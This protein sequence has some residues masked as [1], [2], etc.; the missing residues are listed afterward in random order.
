MMTPE[1]LKSGKLRDKHSLAFPETLPFNDID[2]LEDF[3]KC[4]EFMKG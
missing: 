2:T 3:K 4:E 1:Q